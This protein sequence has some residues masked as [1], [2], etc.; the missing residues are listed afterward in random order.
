MRS[1]TLVYTDDWQL[2]ADTDYP[3]ASDADRALVTPLVASW[4][5]DQLPP[6]AQPDT[7]TVK[8]YDRGVDPVGGAPR[9]LPLDVGTPIAVLVVAYTLGD[10]PGKPVVFQGRIADVQAEPRRGGGLVFTVICSSRLADLGSTNAPT[11]LG[12]TGPEGWLSLFAYP[13]I[14]ADAGVVLDTF[15][16]DSTSDATEGLLSA[17]DMVNDNVSSLDALGQLA[18]QDVRSV[19]RNGAYGPST[20]WLVY[21]TDAA[22][23]Y[24][25]DQD[26][27]T[28]P[29][30]P[31]VLDLAGILVLS[32]DGTEWVAVDNPDYYTDAG[33]G[34]GILLY[35]DQCLVDI[36][37]WSVDRSAMVTTVELTGDFGGVET[38][39]VEHADLVP[40]RQTRS[41]ASP[42][43]VYSG[44]TG[45]AAAILGPRSQVNQ[46]F[47]LTQLT[48]VWSTLTDDQVDAWG[49]EIWP[50][51]DVARGDGGPLGRPVAVV[52]IPDDWSLA[53]GPA[54]FGR[55]MGVTVTVDVARYTTDPDGGV[56]ASGRV[57]LG[58]DLRAIPPTTDVGISLDDLPDS[59]PG[60]PI[61]C[62]NIS[63]TITYDLASLIGA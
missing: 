27:V 13:Q 44:A 24:P 56:P 62:D 18:L 39:R 46:G 45:I 40:P 7:V 63:R 12:G 14:A 34:A 59:G 54:V 5:T 31:R 41:L 55:L 61:T 51:A 53:E 25:Q 9:W 3:D 2:V 35:A 43:D 23:P 6:V 19:W 10:V 17:H 36:G 33:S 42:A 29:Y 32:Y 48:V 4:S 26:Y 1:R 15:D 60:T 38:V 28:A 37:S 21:D 30:D 58:L 49:S 52:Q 20:H 8:I 50:T 16:G 57:M 22:D 47:G 11:V